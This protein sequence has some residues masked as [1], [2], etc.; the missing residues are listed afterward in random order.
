[1]KAE[2]GKGS[3]PTAF[4]R[5]LVDPKSSVKTVAIWASA[6]YDERVSG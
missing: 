3:A 4:G 5:G 2:V 1:L 6:Q